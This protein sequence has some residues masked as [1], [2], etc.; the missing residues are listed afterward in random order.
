MSQDCEIHLQSESHL[1]NILGY[2]ES[3]CEFRNNDG[4][5]L[6][7]QWFLY[8]T[9]NEWSYNCSWGYV[10]VNQ[11]EIHWG[12]I[13]ELCP[14]LIYLECHIEDQNLVIEIHTGLIGIIESSK[15]HVP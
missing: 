12:L 9:V 10:H 15:V 8:R 7:K 2:Q 3:C 1:A 14:V 6:I 11:C 5:R 13:V 4:M